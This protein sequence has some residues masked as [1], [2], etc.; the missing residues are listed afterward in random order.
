MVIDTKHAQSAQGTDEGAV[1]RPPAHIDAFDWARAAGALVIVL[2]HAF[3]C[4]HRASAPEVL[5]AGRMMVEN[6]IALVLA[7]WAVPVF[8]MMSGALML[9]PVRDMSWRKVA[10]HV[11]RMVFV[12]L[13]IGLAFCVIE[14]AVEAGGLSVQV[15]GQSFVN[16]ARGRSWDHLWF[17]YAMIGCYLLTPLL[18][19]FVAQASERE[20]RLVT[21]GMV[22]LLQGVN[23]LSQL[24]GQSLWMP[25]G[26]PVNLSWYVLGYYA[27]TYLRLDRRLAVGAAA[28][29]AGMLA[30]RVIF[31]QS[32]VGLP[33]YLPIVPWSLMVFLAFERLCQTPVSGH[34]LV[35]LLARRSFGIYLIHPLWQHV[36]VR[37]TPIA[38]LPALVADLGLFGASLVLSAASVW[39]LCLIPAFR[40]K[41]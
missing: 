32:W 27:H 21:L 30:V 1:P 18:R 26:L 4:I 9:D 14:E 36:L 24:T 20:L 16:L 17:V 19:A 8:F 37:L 7:R 12:L 41:L 15:L 22:V 35:E 10:R 34:P 5:G 38:S 39:L 11:W 23:T 3:V 28:L 40:D 6:G 13:T 2:L 31:D 33:E 29:M 25:L